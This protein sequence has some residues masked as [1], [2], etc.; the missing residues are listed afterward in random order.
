MPLFQ[1]AQYFISAHHLRDLPP[2][3]GIEIAFAGRSN[4]GKSSAINTLANHTRL[5]YVSKQPGRTQLINF[6]SLGGDR[7]LVDLPGYGY[8]KVPE[9]MR[10]HW[11]L[12]LAAYLSQRSSLH[13]LVLVMDSRHP[14][15]PLDCQM[16]DWFGP[17][18]KPIHVLLTK[19]D[20]MSRS[21]AMKTL[22]AVRKELQQTWGN[23]SVQLFS[24]LKKQGVEE[25]EKVIGAWLNPPEDQVPDTVPEV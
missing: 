18:G 7:Y 5:A 2:A 23:S 14:L 13:G 19:S 10:K 3:T 17:T 16:L 6:F 11:Q 25:A 21:E 20:K 4:A 9:A 12:V 22:A 8:A 15:T 1:N 24:S